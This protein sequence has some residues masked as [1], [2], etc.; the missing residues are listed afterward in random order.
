MSM[1]KRMRDITLATLNDKLEDSQDPVRIIDQF[2]VETRQEIGEVQR[3]YDQCAHHSK[4]LRQQVDHASSMREK[5]EEQAMLALKADEESIAKLALQEKMLYEEKE[6]QYL[7]LWEQSQGTLKELGEQL[8]VLRTEYQT[9]YNKRQ[10]YYARMETLRL[11]QKLNRRT[12]GYESD[13]PKMFDR[14][15]DQMSSIEYETYSLRDIRK[16]GQEA[17][18]QIGEVGSIL[19]QEMARLKEKM[20]RSEGKE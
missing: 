14:L 20:K 19:E 15:D 16:L 13:V 9:V 18:R 4:Q 5:R 17:S 6:R 12:G 3:L 1:F 7:E 2:L 10:Y 8:N 11:Q